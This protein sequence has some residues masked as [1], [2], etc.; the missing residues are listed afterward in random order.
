MGRGTID[1]YSQLPKIVI[2]NKIN[3]INI[4]VNIKNEISILIRK[5]QLLDLELT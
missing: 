1:R 4:M 5:V 3:I 2:Q